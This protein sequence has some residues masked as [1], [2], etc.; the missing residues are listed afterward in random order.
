M[1][2][3]RKTSLFIAAGIAI[4][5]CLTWWLNHVPE[6]HVNGIGLGHYM[7]NAPNGRELH[8]AVEQLGASAVP[9]LTEQI[10]TQP[11][12][13]ALRT[14]TAR[15]RF[16]PE[17][18]LADWK[19]Y[20][21][22]RTLAAYLLVRLGTNAAASLPVALQIAASPE[23]PIYITA[24]TLLRLA[25]GTEH[26]SGATH[27]LLAATLL[28]RPNRSDAYARHIAYDT[29]PTFTKHP[30]LVIPALVRSLHEPGGFR[31]IDTVVR[32]GT[33]AVPYLQ[34]AVKNETNHVMPATVALE[35]ILAG[36]I[37]PIEAKMQPP[38][39]ILWQYPTIGF[40]QGIPP[41]QMMQR[42]A[43][44]RPLRSN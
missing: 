36:E 4:V 34:I 32:L 39:P 15:V 11:L 43:P 9:Y 23:D 10:K 2:L 38:P 12:R 33:N 3:N 6:P 35:R 29:L 18:L 14:F 42:S 30:E 7:A 41:R 8:S 20:Q 44:P 26:E 25:A 24:L 16:Q 21:Q 27:V 37:P 5:A 28:N 31:R 1:R 17:F 22:R 40:Q 19:Q 13:E